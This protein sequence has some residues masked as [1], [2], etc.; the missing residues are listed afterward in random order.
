[1]TGG[2]AAARTLL[3]VGCGRMGT[4]L[5][6]G[7]LARDVAS[8]FVVVEPTGVPPGL[9]GA[10]NV[11]FHRDADTLPRRL[12][13]AAVVFAVKPQTID[14]VLE[15][16]RPWATPATVFLSIVAGKTLAGI[17]RHL[18]PAALVRTMPN[19]PAAI[20]RGFTVACANPDVRPEQRSLCEA[21]LAAVGES[22]WVDDE[23]LLDAVTAISGSGPAYVFLLIEALAR[24]GEREGLAADLAMRLARATVAGAGELARLSDESPAALRESVTSPGGTTRAALDLL[25]APDGLESLIGRA[26]AAAAARSRVLAG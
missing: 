15:S 17:A 4:A 1:M 18:G 23:G 16:Y 13:P 6:R 21:L 11:V 26:V 19:L 10:A 3:L 22:A 25:M 24:A 20:G 5:L 2:D 9:A 8:Q 12:A 7:W 14:T